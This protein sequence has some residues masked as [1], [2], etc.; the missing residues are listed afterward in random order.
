MTPPHPPQRP[1]TYTA[2][3]E[4]R[5]CEY[6]DVAVGARGRAAQHHDRT[7]HEVEVIQSVI[8]PRTPMRGSMNLF[9]QPPEGGAR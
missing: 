9:D 7:G 2:T 1:Y 4:C 8:Y 3:A 6:V 5:D